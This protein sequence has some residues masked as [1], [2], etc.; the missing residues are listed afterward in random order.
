VLRS[1]S[2]A[3]TVDTRRFSGANDPEQIAVEDS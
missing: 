1:L 3:I 2:D